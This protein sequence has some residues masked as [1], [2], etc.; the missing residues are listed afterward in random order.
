MALLEGRA[1]DYA[2]LQEDGIDQLNGPDGPIWLRDVELAE[3]SAE[4]GVA[5]SIAPEAR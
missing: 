5:Y 3:F 2:L 4:P 1:E